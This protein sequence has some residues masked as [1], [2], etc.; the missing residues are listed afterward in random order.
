M[1][2]RKKQKQTEEYKIPQPDI[3]VRGRTIFISCRIDN[4]SEDKVRIELE[5]TQLSISALVQ[6]TTVARKITLPEN[7]TI[8]KKTYRNGILEIIIEREN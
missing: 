1:S 6:N 5:G 7:C 8:S 4:T 3:S 2:A